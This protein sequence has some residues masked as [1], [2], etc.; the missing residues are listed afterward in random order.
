MKYICLV[1]CKNL[2]ED[3]YVTVCLVLTIEVYKSIYRLI[4][5]SII[6]IVDNNL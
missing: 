5:I 1:G 6:I 3:G 4:I 2:P